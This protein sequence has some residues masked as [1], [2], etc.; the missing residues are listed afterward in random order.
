MRILFW[1]DAFY[2]GIG[3]VQVLG[4]ALLRA[5]RRQGHELLVF[6]GPYL[7]D[8]ADPDV[9]DGI[10][11]HRFPFEYLV[12]PHSPAMIGRIKRELAGLLHAFKP[13]LA[14]IFHASTG[15]V[16][17]LES[18]NAA[19]APTLLTLHGNPL[20][21][22]PPINAARR[23]LLCE[24]DWIACCSEALRAEMV[25]LVP[26][27]WDHCS[28]V[29]NS[30]EMPRE[31]PEPLPIAEP[32]IVCIGRLDPQKGFDFALDA[33][34]LVASKLPRA[35][36][37]VAGD[38]PER[39]ALE[40]QADRRGIQEK[41]DFCGWFPPSRVPDLLNQAALVLMPSRFEPFGLVALQAAQMGRPVIASRVGGLPE[42][43][44]DGETGL[45][46]DPENVPLLAQAIES[47][48]AQPDRS[49]EMGAQARAHAERNFSWDRFVGHYEMLYK[50]LILSL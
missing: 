41:V 19:P 29:L 40:A 33:F 48:L 49:V 14:H 20:N 37:V 24:V 9:F 3:G 46:V 50:Q 1:V 27:I 26:E 15:F 13:D 31:R 28:T 38:G 39:A 36:L 10:P 47:L 32:R 42:V 2:P 7:S 34:A 17:Y 8:R 35:R 11:L 44:V 45:L 4:T 21:A 25:Q 5:L 18:A 6:G 30:L 43:V 12:H 22:T 23:R 16:L